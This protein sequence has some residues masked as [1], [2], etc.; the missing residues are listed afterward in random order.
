MKIKNFI[1]NDV[2]NLLNFNNL[3][4]SSSTNH[5]KSLIIYFIVRKLSKIIRISKLFFIIFFKFIV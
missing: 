3:S 4:N 2:N 1:F 5:Y